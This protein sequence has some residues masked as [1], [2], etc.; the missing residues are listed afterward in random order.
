MELSKL[1]LKFLKYQESNL[2]CS[3]IYLSTKLLKKDKNW[4]DTLSYHAK[5]N[6]NDVKLCSKELCLMLRDIPKQNL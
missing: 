6:E 5:Y 3:A 1:D 2:A 4:N